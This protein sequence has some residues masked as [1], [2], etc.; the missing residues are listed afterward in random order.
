M[1]HCS[2]GDLRAMPQRNREVLLRLFRL[3]YT[4]S[5]YPIMWLPTGQTLLTECTSSRNNKNLFSSYHYRASFGSPVEKY[6][7]SK[8]EHLQCELQVELWLMRAWGRRP[9]PADPLHNKGHRTCGPVRGLDIQRYSSSPWPQDSPVLRLWGYK[10]LGIPLFRVPQRHQLV[11]LLRYLVIAPWPNYLKNLDV[12]DSAVG[13]LGLSWWGNL[14]WL[15]K[16]QLWRSLG[17]SSG[18]VRVTA[19][20]GSWMVSQWCF[21]TLNGQILKDKFPATI[22]FFFCY[23]FSTM[24]EYFLFSQV[25]LQPASDSGTLLIKRSADILWIK[26]IINKQIKW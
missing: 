20:E 22:S 7:Q 11:L 2:F 12:Y 23:C 24:V 9:C 18:G 5:F 1:H 8:T 13:S 3:Q 26:S 10:R 19:P 21:L 14:V 6:I 25:L 17:P 15:W 16:Q 4:A